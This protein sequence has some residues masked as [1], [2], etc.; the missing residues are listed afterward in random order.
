MDGVFN[1]VSKDSLASIPNVNKIILKT[2]KLMSAVYMDVFIFSYSFAPKNW[3]IIT[4][5]PIPP[6]IAIIMN[7]VV[8]EY[9][10]PTD[11]RASS[12][13]NLPT[14]TESAIL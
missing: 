14:I 12:L 6:P 3:E 8:N 10:A 1:K 4:D 11:A 13:T 5:E 2:K 7:T 9:E